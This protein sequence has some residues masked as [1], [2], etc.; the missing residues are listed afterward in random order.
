MIESISIENIATYSATTEVL[1]GLSLFNFMFGSNGS[2]KTTVSRIIADEIKYPSCQVKW[3]GGT[4]LQAM[5]Y[6]NDFID[7]NFTQSAE[8]RGVFT[9][10]ESQGETIAKIAAAKGELDKLTAKIDILTQSLQGTDGNG[11][12]KGNL[13]ALESGLKEK[14]WAQKQKHDPKLQG[15]FEGYRNSSEKFKGKV[16]QELTS[17]TASLLSQADLEK[18]AESVFGPTPTSEAFV[19]VIDAT[20]LITY[21]SNPILKKR[22]IGKEDVEIAAMIKKLGN[23]DWVREGRAFYDANDGTCPFCQQRTIEAFAQSLNEYFDETFVAD[24]QAIDDLAT[25]YATESA[26]LQQQLT[27]IIES[28]STF[29]DV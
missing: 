23:S 24:S 20:K 9:L 29:L 1:A 25:N 13:A 6:N 4:K 18:K 14:C 19:T 10:G 8:L 27:A 15:A 7:R 17:N 5:V 28:P 11:G 21:E 16:L 3:K 12:K 26:R 22:V 2:G